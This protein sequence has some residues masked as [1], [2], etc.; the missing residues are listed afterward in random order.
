[1]EVT[2]KRDDLV[3]GLHLVQGVV[4]RRTPQPILANVLLE[5]SEGGIALTATDMEVGLRVTVPAQMKKQAAVTVNARKVYEIA[6]EL[7][8]EDVTLK[9]GTAGWVDVVAG[10]SRFKVVS[11]DPKDYPQLPFGANAGTGTPIRIAAG[12]LREMIDKTLFAVSQDETRFNLSGVYVE[13]A[14][15]GILR[16]V[17]TDGHRLAMIDRSVAD[18]KLPRGVIM[19]RKGLVEVRKLLDETGEAE[20][21]LVVAEKDVR[22]HT[23]QLSFF[24]RLVEGEFPDYR[25][26]VPASTRARAQVN[27]DDF[28][29]AVRRISLLASERSHGVKL[30]FEKGSLELSAS[31][32][33]L[34]EASED[35]EA[36]YGG[37]S[38]SIGFNGR[39]L[40]DVLNVHAQGDVIE[41]GLTEEVGPGLLRG[42]Q[43]PTY[44]YVLMPMR[45]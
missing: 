28:Q 36:S 13:S 11:L 34:G 21:T 5:P 35:I 42:S 40:L 8:A 16:M 37:E 26:V 6:R 44:T 7:A 45:L 39:Y 14:E 43:D 3:R 23:P 27:R 1:M 2:L 38:M 25:Q 19:P 15:G 22:V 10:R 32:P 4:E 29:A 20:L 17:A 18:A 30:H 33:D 41:L 31:N 9:V 12:T 24:M